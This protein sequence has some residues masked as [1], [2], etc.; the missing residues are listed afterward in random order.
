M[1]IRSALPSIFWQRLFSGAVLSAVSVR[2][3]DEDRTV[4]AGDLDRLANARALVEQVEQVVARFPIVC[5]NPFADGLPRWFD[6]LEGLEAQKAGSGL[7][8]V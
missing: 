2:I 1:T 7:G 8:Q 6:W 5:G 3:E 4:F